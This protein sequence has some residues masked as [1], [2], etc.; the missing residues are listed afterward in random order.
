MAGFEFFNERRGDQEN[1][2]RN[3]K[4]HHRKPVKPQTP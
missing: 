1:G 2:E 4:L 3:E